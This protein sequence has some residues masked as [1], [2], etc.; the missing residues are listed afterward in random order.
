MAFQRSAGH[1]LVTVSVVFTREHFRTW[2]ALVQS[3]GGNIFNAQY[4]TDCMDTLFS[5]KPLQDGDY[6]PMFVQRISDS[7]PVVPDAKEG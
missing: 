5:G 7:R 6:V 2:I 1:K 4:L 3:D